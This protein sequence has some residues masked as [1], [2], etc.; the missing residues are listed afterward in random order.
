ML[1]LDDHE[2][3]REEV[4][5]KIREFAGADDDDSDEEVRDKLMKNFLIEMKDE[6]FDVDTENIGEGF[7]ELKKQV[8]AQLKEMGFE[9]DEGNCLFILELLVV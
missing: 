5:E 1:V 7:Q 2:K 9:I 4:R 3:L 8:I 6:G